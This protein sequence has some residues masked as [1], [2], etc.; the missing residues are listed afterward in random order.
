MAGK[1]RTGEGW[2]ARTK[3]TEEMLKPTRVTESYKENSEFVFTIQDSVLYS[4][5]AGA[6]N[7]GAGDAFLARL[8]ELYD[9][10]HRGEYREIRPNEG[11]DLS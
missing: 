11:I 5:G 9:P 1:L 10:A 6:A 3:E 8:G 7:A 4:Q 2:D